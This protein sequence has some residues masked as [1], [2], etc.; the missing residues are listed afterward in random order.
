MAGELLPYDPKYETKDPVKVRTLDEHLI[1]Q[2]KNLQ[3]Y[4]RPRGPGDTVHDREE[5][6]ATNA[7]SKGG[8]V[9]AGSPTCCTARYKH[10]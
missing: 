10:K 8:K 9:K 2:P 6:D 5:P 1:K 3:E 7:Y 4:L